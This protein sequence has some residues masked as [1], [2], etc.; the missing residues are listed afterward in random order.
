MAIRKINSRSIGDTGVATADIADGS[1]TTAKL[2]VD[3][4]TTPKIADTVNLGRRNI[5]INGAMQIWQRATAATT[6]VNN[7]QSVDRF[8]TN[9]G[10]AGVYT[11]ERSTDSPFGSGFSLKAQV[12][13]ADTSIAGGDYAYLHQDIEGQNL[14]HLL[15][16]NSSAKTITLSFWVKSNKTGTYTVIFRKL[17]N[18]AYH[19][20]HEYTIDVAN[21]WEKKVI[22]ISPTAGSTSFLTASAGAIVNSNVR[23]FQIGFNLTFGSDYNGA[24]NNTWT[25]NTTHY[26]TTNQ[27]NWLDDTS[28]NFYLTEVQLELG[29]TATPFEHHSY[30]DEL[31]RCQRYYQ[32]NYATWYGVAQE[33]GYFVSS[34]ITYKPDLRAA[35]T[36]A[37]KSFSSGSSGRFTSTS[38]TN[39]TINGTTIYSSPT[40]AGGNS[41]YLATWSADA[42]F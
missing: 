30:G 29:D 38:A 40:S 26:A 19:L 34:N 15:Y 1:I 32:I 2:A 35:P 17:S 7:Y 31:L 5:I 21:T 8:R 11:T 42:E 36:V 39:S 13:T 14:Q 6:A 25:T 27:V 22:T 10:G 41:G 9:I 3:A 24:T 37:Q 16:G 28:N 18:T 23:G 20:V 33:A 4:V 12:T